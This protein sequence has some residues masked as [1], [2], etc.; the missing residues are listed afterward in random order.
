MLDFVQSLAAWAVGIVVVLA[1]IWL[2]KD[3]LVSLFKGGWV[4]GATVLVVGVIVVY[5]FS[6]VL[7]APAF[8]GNEVEK[9]QD[10]PGGKVDIEIGG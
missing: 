7:K 5:G 2:C 1:L 10:T 8:I 3:F 9:I 4:A 6:Q